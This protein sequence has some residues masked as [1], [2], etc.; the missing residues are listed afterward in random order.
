MDEDKVICPERRLKDFKIRSA[1][2][3]NERRSSLSAP[4]LP[5]S[6]RRF[7]PAG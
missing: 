1:R 2:E 7:S 3:R 6:R 5:V 4:A